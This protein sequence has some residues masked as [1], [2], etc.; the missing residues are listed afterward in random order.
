MPVNKKYRHPIIGLAAELP[1][2]IQLFHSGIIVP[3]IK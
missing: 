2:L 1:L 3:Q